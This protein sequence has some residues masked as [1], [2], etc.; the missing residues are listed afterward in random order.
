MVIGLGLFN[1]R[2]VLINYKDQQ[3]SVSAHMQALGID[4]ND[5]WIELPLRLTQEGIMVEISQN[6]QIYKNGVGYWSNSICFLEK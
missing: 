5:G 1:N 2:A 3:L 4:I 6:A